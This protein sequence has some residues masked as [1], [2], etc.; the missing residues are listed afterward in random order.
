MDSELP[1]AE[2]AGERWSDDYGPTF[3]EK[4]P[5][6]YVW[7]GAELHMQG[8]RRVFRSLASTLPCCWVL[9]SYLRDIVLGLI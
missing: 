3:T 1:C 6:K 7:C 8:I 2:E 5:V 9:V 4:F